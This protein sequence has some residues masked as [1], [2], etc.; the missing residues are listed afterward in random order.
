MLGGST[1]SLQ[2]ARVL[3]ALEAFGEDSVLAWIESGRR[4]RGAARVI[5]LI[6]DLSPS[7]ALTL[8]RALNEL[9]RV[10][11]ARDVIGALL[12][13]VLGGAGV[14]QDERRNGNRAA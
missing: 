13:A 7:E 3:D 4:H 10:D 9:G 6:D 14:V 1:V 12:T 8:A 2:P 11:E 5:L